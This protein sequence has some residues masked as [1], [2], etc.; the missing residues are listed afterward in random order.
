MYLVQCHYGSP[1]KIGTNNQRCQSSADCP[2]THQCEADHNV[3]CPRPRKIYV[4]Y[5][6]YFDLFSRS[7]LFS[8]VT[9]G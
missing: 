7:N 8:T 1:L 6:N 3:C 2:S 4:N 5:V 9:F